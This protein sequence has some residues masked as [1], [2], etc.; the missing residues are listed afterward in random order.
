[1][2]DLGKKMEEKLGPGSDF[3]KKIKEQAEKLSSELQKKVTKE[4]SAREGGPKTGSDKDTS[5]A[6]AVG[7]DRQRERRIAVLEDQIRKLADE[8]KALKADDDRD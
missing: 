1:M 5:K 6:P 4:A 8:L 2:K 7:K 3:E